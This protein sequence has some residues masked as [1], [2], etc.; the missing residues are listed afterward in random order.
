MDLAGDMLDGVG[1]DISGSALMPDS[2]PFGVSVDLNKLVDI[3][4]VD[5]LDGATFEIFC[6]LLF[7][8]YPNKSYITAKQKGD[9]GVDFV[10]IGNDKKGLIGQ[11]KFTTQEVLGW[12]AVKEVAA[13]SPAY[14]IKHQGIYFEKVA[15]TNKRFNST[16]IE[17]A[18]IL[19]VKLIDR[20]ELIRLLEKN[21]IKEIALDEA[22]FKSFAK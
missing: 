16:A 11:C 12:D 14:Q 21:Q 1:S 8:A 6:G 10:V 2:G 7:G 15:V 5:T 19:G 9:G 20:N 22:I 13:G 17:Q 3:N 4:R 18:Q